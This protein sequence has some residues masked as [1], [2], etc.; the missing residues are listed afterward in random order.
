MHKEYLCTNQCFNVQQVDIIHF[1]LLCPSALV[2]FTSSLS[3]GIPDDVI[4]QGSFIVQ[5]VCILLTRTQ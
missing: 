2:L 5:L 1:L 4:F 3:Q